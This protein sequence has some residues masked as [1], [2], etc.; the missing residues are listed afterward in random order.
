MRMIWVR[1]ATFLS[2]FG[3]IVVAGLVALT[4]YLTTKATVMKMAVGPQ[5]S[6]DVEFVDKLA[7]KFRNRLGEA[8]S[9]FEMVSEVR[10]LGFFTGIVF[11]Q[12]RVYPGIFGQMIVMSLFREHGILTQLCGNNFN[13]LRATPPLN[14]SEKSLDRFIAALEQVMEVAHSS[15]HFWHD[16]LQLAASTARDLRKPA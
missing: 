14:S 2:I 13:V 10:G 3:F 5:G 12:R 16:A 6:K 7:E 1:Y 11:G 9:R 4:V 15:K 8:L